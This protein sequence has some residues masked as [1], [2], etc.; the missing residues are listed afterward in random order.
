MTPQLILEPQQAIHLLRQCR[1]VVTSRDAL[2]YLQEHLARYR[3]LSLYR[4]FFPREFA[5][6]QTSPYSL[7]EC[8]RSPK[9]WEFLNLVNDRLF[10]LTYLDIEEC[11]NDVI[12]PHLILVTPVGLGWIDD[13]SIETLRAGFSALLPLTASSRHYLEE[14]DAFGE[15]W[16]R[17]E[18]DETLAFANIAH[19]SAIDARQFRR[20][21]CQQGKPIQYAP[22][23]LKLVDFS[24]GNVWLDEPGGWMNGVYGTML[25]WSPENVRFLSR[26][27]I[28]AERI[29]HAIDP[30]LD[31]LEADLPLRLR[32]IIDLWNSA[33]STPKPT[34]RF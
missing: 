27:Y 24:T 22:L 12:P 10:P 17:E 26:K 2:E 3:L 4:D 30:F 5:Q 16:Y 15:E 31:W 23:T 7:N 20:I 1:A 32:R 6:S 19:P 8:E 13:E 18:F 34:A 9:E 25:A 11:V 33:S 28:Q 29:I 14:M 21:C